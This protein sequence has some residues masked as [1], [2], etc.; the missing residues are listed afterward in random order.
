VENGRLIHDRVSQVF[1]EMIAQSGDEALT[2]LSVNQLH[3]IKAIAGAEEVTITELANIMGVSPPS[4][5][6]MVDRLKEKGI[7]V[8]ER[9]RKDRRKVVVRLTDKVC[10]QMNRVHQGIFD[11]FI[12]LVEKIG[13]ET[14][15]KWC[16]VLSAVKAVLEENES[17][18]Q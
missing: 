8:R 13:P 7:I 16:E 12:E 6:V 1:S 18:K 14:A 2:E 11:S 17:P 4:A 15:R 10:E 5:S 3:T 9:S